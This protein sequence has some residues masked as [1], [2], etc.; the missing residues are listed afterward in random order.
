M[1]QDGAAHRGP[2]KLLVGAAA[3]EMLIVVREQPTSPR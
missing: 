2:A 1:M 3:F